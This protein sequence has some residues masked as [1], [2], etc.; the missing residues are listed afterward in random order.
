MPTSTEVRSAGRPQSQARPS[1]AEASM[2]GRP[3]RRPAPV[4]HG[5]SRPARGCRSARIRLAATAATRCPMLLT[6]RGSTVPAASRAPLAG[7]APIAIPASRPWFADSAA[8]SRRLSTTAGSAA[9][10]AEPNRPVRRPMAALAASSQPVP[11]T[12]ARKAA[13]SRPVRPA[14]SRPPITISRRRSCRSASTPPGSV[15]GHASE[16]SC[17]GDQAGQRRLA[18]DHERHE[19]DREAVH[20]GREGTGGVAREPDQVVALAQE[21]GSGWRRRRPVGGAAGLGRCG[22]GRTVGRA[23]VVAQVSVRNYSCGSC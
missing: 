15:P 1:R 5:S 14:P 16:R 10:E 22:H 6:T 19:G 7:P 13:T 9:S 20:G 21:A 23:R 12:P 4:R 17:R 18:G 8:P 3:V 11:S 2:L